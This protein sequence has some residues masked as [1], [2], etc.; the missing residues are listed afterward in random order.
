MKFEI[1]SK[2]ADAGL[3]LPVRKTA[4]SAGYDFEVAEDVI[5]PSYPKIIPFLQ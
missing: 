1:I 2:Y 3:N 4:K 5:V